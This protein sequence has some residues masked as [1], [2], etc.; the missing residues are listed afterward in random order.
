MFA[1][2]VGVY[3]LLDMFKKNA[4]ADKVK[5]FVLEHTAETFPAAARAVVESGAEVGLHG[6]SHQGIQ[7]MTEEEERDVLLKWYVPC[8]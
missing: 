3:W 4:I 7:Q 1:G 5:W 2:Q 8:T 6:Y